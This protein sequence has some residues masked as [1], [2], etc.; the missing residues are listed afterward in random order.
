M[1]TNSFCCPTELNLR[2][3]CNHSIR[4]NGWNWKL[5][6]FCA[7]INQFYFSSFSVIDSFLWG[8]KKIDH[9]CEKKS[10]LESHANSV[11]TIMGR[12]PKVSSFYKFLFYFIG[13]KTVWLIRVFV[14]YKLAWSH[15]APYLMVMISYSRLS[16]FT[17]SQF[18]SSSLTFTVFT[19]SDVI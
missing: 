11:F 6:S 7:K 9:F 15:I 5:M 3:P 1:K 10:I 18:V 17:F 14:Y 16:A 8:L 13:H 4:E 19:A 2:F 12:Q